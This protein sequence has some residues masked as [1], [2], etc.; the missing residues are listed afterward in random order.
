MPLFDVED[1]IQKAQQAGEFDR[2]RGKGKPFTHLDT[3]PFEHL[4]Q[5][6]GVVPRWL[7]KEY[8]IRAKI[9]IA[10]QAIVRTHDWVL[11]ALAGGSVDRGYARTEWHTARHIFTQRL[12]EINQLIRIFNLELPEPLRH[13]QR[14]PLKIDEELA[15]LGLTEKF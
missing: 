5:E 12:D 8:E 11:A 4:V 14:F 7:E 3:D 13:L 6:Q 2:L 15:Q 9:E 1:H 10:R